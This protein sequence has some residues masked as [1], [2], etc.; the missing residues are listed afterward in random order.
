MESGPEEETSGVLKI[1]G[2]TNFQDRSKTQN[3]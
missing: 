3:P 2:Y 1:K